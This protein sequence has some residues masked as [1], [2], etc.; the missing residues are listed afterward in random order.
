MAK[1]DVGQS[2]TIKLVRDGTSRLVQVTMGE[3]KAPATSDSEAQS[4][5]EATVSNDD[6]RSF[7]AESE[8][9]PES[10]SQELDAAL[11]DQYF[12]DFLVSR[13]R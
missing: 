1:T 12:K 5:D 10:S 7:D 2:V 8:T 3:L 4:I 6:N 9:E 13:R 11:F